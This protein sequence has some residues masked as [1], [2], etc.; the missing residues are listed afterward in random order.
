MIKYIE[1]Y[2]CMKHVYIYLP[3]KLHLSKFVRI[4]LDV[5]LFILHFTIYN[6][7]FSSLCRLQ[8]VAYIASLSILHKKIIFF[9]LL[10]V[11]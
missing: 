9:N 2:L 1:C 7:S 10:L 4:T 11:K 5:S 6:S 3:S 8:S